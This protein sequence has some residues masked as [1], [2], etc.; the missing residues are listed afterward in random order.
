MIA[1][2][3]ISSHGS[4]DLSILATIGSGIL[5]LIQVF[6][7]S[8]VLLVNRYVDLLQLALEE[9]VR[10][11]KLIQFVLNFNHKDYVNELKE[12]QKTYT[13]EEARKKQEQLLQKY[14]EELKKKGVEILENNVTIENRT[15]RKEI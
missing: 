3:E 12:D 4:S 9:D 15:L 5:L 8:I 11:S 14:I 10:S 7:D 2:Y 13:E 1:V 6:V